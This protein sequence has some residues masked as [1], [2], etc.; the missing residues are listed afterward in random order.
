MQLATITI[1][2]KKI[3]FH[4][5]TIVHLPLLITLILLTIFHSFSD[6][7][8]DYDNKILQILYYKSFKFW[9]N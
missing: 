5:L 2:I 3:L 1:I 6:K 8:N 7:D 9:Q 4:K